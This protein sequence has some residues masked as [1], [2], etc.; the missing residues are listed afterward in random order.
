MGDREIS[1]IVIDFE[2]IRNE[3]LNESIFNFMKFWVG[4]ALR[5]L[6]GDIDFAIPVKIKGTP[7]E[8]RSFVSALG[9]QKSY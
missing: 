5:V 2:K 8:V 4:K 7:A 1:E 3:Q 9:N 6:L